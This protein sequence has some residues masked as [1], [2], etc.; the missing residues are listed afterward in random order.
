MINVLII[1]DDPMVAKFNAIYLESIPGFAIAGIAQNAEEGWIFYQ[2]N[3]VDLIL[4]DVY[5]GGKTGLELLSDFRRAANPVD[6]IIITAANDKESVQTALRY[7]AVDY[8]IKPFSFERFQEALLQYEQKHQMMNDNENVSQE[9]IDTFL[10]KSEKPQSTVLELPKGLT[11]RTFSTIV[12]QIIKR[13]RGAFS[14]ADLAEE[15]GISRVS[16]RKYLNH[17]VETDMLTVDIVYQETGRPLHRFILKPE[18]IEILRT[19]SRE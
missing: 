11:V 8:L 13:Q 15:T 10:L 6:V 14:A 4:L 1:E 16:V 3:K 2:T 7:G 12:K 9:E 18:K 19:I 17:L 5:M